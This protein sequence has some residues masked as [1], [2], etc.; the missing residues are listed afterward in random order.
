MGRF[1][2]WLW[3]TF[4]NPHSDS[5]RIRYYVFNLSLERRAESGRIVISYCLL[6]L[7]DAPRPVEMLF[8]NRRIVIV[9][10]TGLCLML[11]YL[12]RLD[13]RRLGLLQSYSV[14]ETFGGPKAT[15]PDSRPGHVPG[16]ALSSIC[17]AIYFLF[18]PRRVGRECFSRFSI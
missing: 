18:Q 3:Q 10:I 4:L 8:K 13:L 5:E 17:S 12:R 7:S 14:I 11:F 15:A 1:Q 2:A 9:S 6:T 16:T